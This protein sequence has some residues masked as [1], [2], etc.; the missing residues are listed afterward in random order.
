MQLV[1]D[2]IEDAP[3]K[4]AHKVRLLGAVPLFGGLSIIGT[5]SVLKTVQ[6]KGCGGS[7]PS[8]SANIIR[9]EQ[10]NNIQV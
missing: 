5:A 9:P 8:P 1:L 6:P 2:V 4:G 7:S 3:Y 10:Q